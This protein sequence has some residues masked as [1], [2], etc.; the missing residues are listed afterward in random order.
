[1][2]PSQLNTL[3]L[4]AQGSSNPATLTKA[5]KIPLRVVVRNTGPNLVLLAHD[6]G[7]LSNAPAT[8]NTFKLFPPFEDTYVLAPG[9]G[10]YAVSIGAGGEVSVAIS[11]ALPISTGDS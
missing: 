4:P 2:K 10:L 3:A 6:A 9:E 7:T 8:A 5:A 11:E 1:M